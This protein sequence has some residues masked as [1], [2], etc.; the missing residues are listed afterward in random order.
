M[1]PGGERGGGGCEGRGYDWQSIPD[2]ERTVSTRT[3]PATEVTLM[4]SGKLKLP[5]S[6]W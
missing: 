3:S 1:T 6:L 4:G 2:E 5:I